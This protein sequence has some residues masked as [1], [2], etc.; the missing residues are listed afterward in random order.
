MAN[1]AI[2]EIAAAVSAAGKELLEAQKKGI[3]RVIL[4]AEDKLSMETRSLFTRYKDLVLWTGEFDKATHNQ[5]FST[6]RLAVKGIGDSK[7]EAANAIRCRL[8][9][10]NN[11]T[12]EEP[13]IK[14][15]SS[16]LCTNSL[17]SRAKPS[18]TRG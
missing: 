6:I 7:T 14:I 8:E 13:A 1:Y 11:F 10:F 16:R 4:D 18:M 17:S 12:L 2:S 3:R 9:E 5:V 15:H